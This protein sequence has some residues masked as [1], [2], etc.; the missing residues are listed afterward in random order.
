[1]DS[2]CLRLPVILDDAASAG[3]ER[4]TR[5][6][7]FAAPSLGNLQ[8]VAKVAGP[9]VV[10]WCRAVCRRGSVRPIVRCEIITLVEGREG[11]GVNRL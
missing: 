5:S 1:V 2:Q 7:E 6:A 11:I 3:R 10:S 4:L 9:E 8:F